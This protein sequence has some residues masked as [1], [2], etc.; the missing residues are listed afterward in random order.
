M[1]WRVLHRFDSVFH[2]IFL[3]NQCTAGTASNV[4]AGGTGR[5]Q[6]R[7]WF[8]IEG[9]EEIQTIEKEHKSI[10]NSELKGVGKTV[11]ALILL[12]IEFLVAS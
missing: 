10:G 11:G 3:T 12:F 6:V 2:F 4:D 8:Q 9:F 5:D 7:N 1:T